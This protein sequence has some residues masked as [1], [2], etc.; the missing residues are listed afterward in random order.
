MACSQRQ[1]Q[2]PPQGCAVCKKAATSPL[3]D[4]DD[5]KWRHGCDKAIPTRQSRVSPP[6]AACCA[7]PSARCAFGAWTVTGCDSQRME[8]QPLRNQTPAVQQ[9]MVVVASP[10]RTHRRLAAMRIGRGSCAG[11]T[12]AA[13]AQAECSVAKLLDKN[14]C[15]DEERATGSHDGSCPAGRAAPVLRA[16]GQRCKP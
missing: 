11:G 8:A 15:F 9:E 12:Q 5:Q 6:Q 2:G 1:A 4:P 14:C 13:A 16:C 3:C 10:L 7:P